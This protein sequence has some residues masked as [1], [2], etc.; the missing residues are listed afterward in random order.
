MDLPMPN[1]ILRMQQ[2]AAMLQADL[3]AKLSST[4]DAFFATETAKMHMINA[5]PPPSQMRAVTGPLS[6]AL[7]KSTTPTPQ[8][9]VDVLDVGSVHWSVCVIVAVREVDLEC[10]VLPTTST[11]IESMLVQTV[12]FNHV[13]RQR[14][15]RSIAAGELLD[16][17]HPVTQTWA[18][19]FV[20]AGAADAEAYFV[21]IFR[22]SHPSERIQV[23]KQ[24]LRPSDHRHLTDADVGRSV[25]VM[26]SSELRW[27]SG[28]HLHKN[29]TTQASAHEDGEF[30]IKVCVPETQHDGTSV[31]R[32]VASFYGLIPNSSKAQIDEFTV[33]S[34]FVRTSGDGSSLY[35]GKVLTTLE[36]LAASAEAATAAAHAEAVTAARTP[37]PALQALQQ[38]VP[39]NTQSDVL[40]QEAAT[41]PL[42][43]VQPYETT[44]WMSPEEKVV[45][46]TEFAVRSDILNFV[47]KIKEGRHGRKAELANMMDAGAGSAGGVRVYANNEKLKQRRDEVAGRTTLAVSDLSKTSAK[48]ELYTTEDT[49]IQNLRQQQN[50]RSPVDRNNWDI[51]TSVPR[52]RRRTLRHTVF[53]EQHAAQH[54][55]HP[56][57]SFNPMPLSVYRKISPEKKFSSAVAAR[58]LKMDV[59]A[60]ES[61]LIAEQMHYSS[62]SNEAIMGD[63]GLGK[64]TWK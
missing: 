38:L 7:A 10:D 33:P 32:S 5:P 64:R 35:Q 27:Q 17:F 36:Q 46:A 31:L 44:C 49:H 25:E 62:T 50:S 59:T 61:D 14:T 42:R 12:S 22:P 34:V 2:Q 48:W 24:L 30:G 56:H 41:T 1:Y 18:T 13:R 43:D 58:L 52:R 4:A 20:A 40:E 63:L 9:F 3:A 26:N 39:T 28:Y 6:L 11:E 47:N 55:Y 54:P 51:S 45:T 8:P 37:L 29:S 53:D 19:G 23:S 21:H 60:K 57:R 15:V 16:V